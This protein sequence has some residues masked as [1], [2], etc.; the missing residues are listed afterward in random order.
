[1]RPRSKWLLLFLLLSPF[2]ISAA[3]LSLLEE[4]AHCVAYRV[5]KTTLF[6]KS[7]EVVGRNCD[8]SAQ[9]LP[10]VGGLYHIEV[11]IPIRSFSSGDSERDRDVM[12]ILKSEERAELTFKSTSRSASSWR[13]LFAQKDFVMEGEL[14]IGDKSFPV[15]MNSRYQESPDNAEIDGLAT[16]KFQDFGI[17]PPKVGGGILASVK[18]D[19]ELHYRFSSQRI[20]GADSIR[21]STPVEEALDKVDKIENDSIKAKSEKKEVK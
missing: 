5:K 21:V 8:V 12:K 11:N 15:K 20:L 4:G 10:E 3:G 7:D 18:P 17:K 19:L 1:M 14:F 9:V 2:S 13:E 16:M 6:V